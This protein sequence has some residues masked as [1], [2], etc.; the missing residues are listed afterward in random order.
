MNLITRTIGSSL[1]KKYIMAI[2]GGALFVFVIG[3]LVGNLQI[4]LG[5]EAIN[6]YGHFL[7]SNKEILWP[8]RLGLIAMVLLHVWSAAKLTAENKTARPIA[9]ANNPTPVAASYASRTML[10]SGLIIAA[11]VIYHLLHYTVQVKAINFTGQNFVGLHDEKGR[12]DV[13]RMMIAGFSQPLVAGFYVLA[14]ALLCLHLSHG[15]SAMFQSVGLKNEVYGPVIDR[16]APIVAW[17][18]FLG[19]VSI[20]VA[21]LC[22][23]GKG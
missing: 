15:A 13:F 7:Q 2:S 19:Y 21:V 9:Y 6:R 11:F 3:H 1:G 18:I 23:F 5:P 8:V 17:V 10:M 4:F 16:V 22:G 20:P 14:M 12:H